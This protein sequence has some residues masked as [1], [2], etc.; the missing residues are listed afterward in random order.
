M[1]RH[2]LPRGRTVQPMGNSEGV[3]IP[4]ELREKFGIERGDELAL[5][6]DEAGEIVFVVE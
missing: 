2:R 1:G 5:E 3:T 6:Y 4:S